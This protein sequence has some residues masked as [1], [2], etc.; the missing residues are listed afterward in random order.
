MVSRQRMVEV[1]DVALI[2]MLI[3]IVLGMVLIVD[4]WYL[5]KYGFFGWIREKAGPFQKWI[6]EMMAAL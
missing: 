3:I 1:R 6:E 4:L 5:E 2:I